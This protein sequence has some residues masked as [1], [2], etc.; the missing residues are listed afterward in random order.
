MGT[1]Q[2]PRLSAM[3]GTGAAAP[4]P[5]VR[6]RRR[7]PVLADVARASEP[8]SPV[9]G[10]AKVGAPFSLFC[11]LTFILIARPQDYIPALVPLRLALLSTLLTVAVTLF[12]PR[13]AG[14]GPFA[15]R[16]T[17]LYFLFYAVMIGG[18]PFAV[19]R[20][21][22]FDEVITKY[23]VNMA[24]FVLFLVH[25]DSLPK[26]KRVA[27]VLVIAG[28]IFTMFGL[29]NGQFESGRY[30]TGSRMFDPNDIAFVEISLLGFALWVV[31][32]RF[33][34][35]LK[36]VATTT[37]LSGVILTLYTASRGGLLGLTTF[38]LLFLGL[39]VKKVSASFKVALLV[40][41]V[42]GTA[43]NFD[44]L[45]I[46][47]YMT[48][49]SLEND[50]NFEQGGRA[51]IWQRGFRLFVDDPLTGVGVGGFAAAIGEQRREE[52]FIPVWQTAHSAYLLVL[53]ETGIVGFVAFLLLIR[54]T[55]ATFN[56]LRRRAGPVSDQDFSVLSGLLLIGFVAQLVS[57]M[58]L[59]QAYSMFFTLAFALSGA[60]N[61]LASAR[62]STGP[63]VLP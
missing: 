59:S 25:V 9:A 17:R 42:I 14:P 43:A 35:I 39:R 4:S 12:Q 5:S 58:F 51:D 49:G 19:Y 38:F 6:W 50:Y 33:P 29:Q 13:K 11:L 40:I 36:A 52:G 15:A 55:L 24:F 57:A 26:L 27:G 54:T 62:S 32:G 23:V 34:L 56:R 46:D 21:G 60:M 53:T 31:V 48:L 28:F 22:A 44:K 20:P 3:S 61:R 41:L 8:A 30:F 45:N 10:T 1:I 2:H 37:I 7:E 47:R 63:V 18:I 16:E